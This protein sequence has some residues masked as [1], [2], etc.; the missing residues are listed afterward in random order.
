MPIVSDIAGHSVT[1]ALYERPAGIYFR[2]STVEFV[3]YTFE[4]F[5]GKD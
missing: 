5:R 1:H 2:N 4:L 3:Q